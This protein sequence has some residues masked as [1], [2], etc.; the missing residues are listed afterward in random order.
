M[1]K[2]AF[3]ASPRVSL[4]PPLSAEATVTEHL[5]IVNVSRG[6]IMVEHRSMLRPGMVIHLSLRAEKGTQILRGRV[7][8]TSLTATAKTPW[9]TRGFV[10]RSGLEILDPAAPVVQSLLAHPGAV[11]EEE[12]E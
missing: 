11:R 10:Y 8:W 12:R 6:G 5:T 4:E 3:R 7:A 2:L 1:R 9:V